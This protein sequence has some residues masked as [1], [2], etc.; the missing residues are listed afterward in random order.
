MRTKGRRRDLSL[1]DA[2]AQ[3]TRGRVNS[4]TLTPLGPAHPQ[5]PHPVSALLCCPCDVQGLSSQV[6]QLMRGR[7]SSPL[8]N[9]EPGVQIDAGGEGQGGLK[10]GGYLPLVHAVA[11]EMNSRARSPILIS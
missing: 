3:Q 11:Q 9:P 5:T 6:L 4:P 2:T 7:N 8:M 1:A 10:I